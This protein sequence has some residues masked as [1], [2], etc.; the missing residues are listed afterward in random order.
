VLLMFQL[1]LLFYIFATGEPLMAI[2]DLERSGMVSVPV[3]LV[4]LISVLAGIAAA[5]DVSRRWIGR[6]VEIYI[7]LFERRIAGRRMQM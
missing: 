6:G 1:M 7:R 3:V 4:A 5:V 2:R